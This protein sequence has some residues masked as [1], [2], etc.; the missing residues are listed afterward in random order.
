[1]QHNRFWSAVAIAFLAIVGTAAMATPSS[2]APGNGAEHIH[3]EWHEDGLDYV[4]DGLQN[5]TDARDPGSHQMAMV[6]GTYDATLR[7][8]PGCE[9]TDSQA[10]KQFT[11]VTGGDGI[12]D[13]QHYSFT[14]EFGF[15]GCQV[16]ITCTTNIYVQIA[17]TELKQHV[18]ENSCASSPSRLSAG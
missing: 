13:T 11:M 8:Y 7:V 4:I 18:A 10:F 12:Y 15:H 1:M 9:I 3:V 17:G 6:H 2:A 16:D 14:Q 5:L